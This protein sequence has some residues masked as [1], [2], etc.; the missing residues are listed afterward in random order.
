METAGVGG[1]IPR[2]VA[3]SHSS[4]QI[5]SVLSSVFYQVVVAFNP[6]HWGGLVCSE[7]ARTCSQSCRNP[8][9]CSDSEYYS[10]FQ[11]GTLSVP[12]CTSR[13]CGLHS[14]WVWW[15]PVWFLWALRWQTV[16]CFRAV[17][18]FP[19]GPELTQRR[20]SRLYHL[21]LF[22]TVLPYLY[23]FEANTSVTVWSV[24][25]KPVFRIVLTSFLLCARCFNR[26]R[27]IKM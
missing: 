17:Y 1:M 4:L 15:I 3:G 24:A 10:I 9:S 2:L 25:A 13:C 26:I 21:S 12:W 23:R 27:S 19:N 5:S 16:L 20:S 18:F 6:N 22:I 8:A 7:G 14:Y 11:I